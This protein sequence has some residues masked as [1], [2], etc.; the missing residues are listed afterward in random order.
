MNGVSSECHLESES[1]RPDGDDENS[2]ESDTQEGSLFTR[3]GEIVENLPDDKGANDGT[4]TGE[5]GGL[6][7]TR[8]TISNIVVGVDMYTDSL[9]HEFER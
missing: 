5:E 3:E 9:E 8:F 1:S 6:G 4:D 2:N 7:K